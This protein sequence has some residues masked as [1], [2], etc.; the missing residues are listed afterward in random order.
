[1]WSNLALH[2]HPEPHRVFPEWHRVT[3]TKGS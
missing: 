3:A 1:L 2:W